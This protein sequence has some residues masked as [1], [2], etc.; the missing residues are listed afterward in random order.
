M[1]TPVAAR[2]TIQQLVARAGFMISGFIVTVVLARELGAAAYAVYGLI[3]SVLLWVESSAAMGIPSALGRLIP[4]FEKKNTAQFE[5][6][7][8][9]L[10][11]VS[12]LVIF[13]VAYGISPTLVRFFGLP[14]EATTLFRIAFLDIPFY[15]L[16]VGYH[17]MFS[18]YRRYGGMALA[19]TGYSIT[20]L[21][22]VVLIWQF[23]DLTLESVFAANIFTSI[24]GFLCLFS[25]APL[26]WVRP[27]LK[28]VRVIL[29]VSIPLGLIST[30]RQILLNLDLWLLKALG[31]SVTVVGLYVAAGN[32]PKMLFVI[33]TT[34][35]IVLFSSLARAVTNKNE[36]LVSTYIQNTVRFVL[37]VLLPFCIIIGVHA[38]EFLVLIFSATYINAAPFLQAQLVGVVFQSLVAVQLEIL[39]ATSR[40]VFSTILLIALVV[41]AIVLSLIMIPHFGAVGA[42]GV[43]IVTNIIGFV[44]TGTIVAKR[45]GK[46]ICGI[47]LLRIILAN[48]VVGILAYVIHSPTLIRMIFEC[49]MLLVVYLLLLLVSRELGWRDLRVFAFWQ[50]G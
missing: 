2:G 4:E 12:A 24:V 49:A 19:I 45:Y 48:I 26:K 30:V 5:S 33:P 1:N 29:S 16:Y 21:L 9:V 43:L 47:T 34:I 31:A 6:T 11:L 17:G 28:L 8:L 7:A 22:G 18:G 38:E 27:D 10:I 3:M 13:F 32:L 42:A 44:V 37:L 39:G 41:L 15:A 50:K 20:K 36:A 25:L 23:F 46:L 14:T 35:G 40:F